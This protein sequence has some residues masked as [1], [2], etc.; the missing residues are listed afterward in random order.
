MGCR[1]AGVLAAKLCTDLAVLPVSCK[2]ACNK[3]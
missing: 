3:R 1:R 2:A